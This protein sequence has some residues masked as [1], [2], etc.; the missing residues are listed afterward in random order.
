MSIRY[1]PALRVG[2]VLFLATP[3]LIFSVV[4]PRPLVAAGLLGV[5]LVTLYGYISKGAGFDR[6][7]TSADDAGVRSTITLPVAGFIVLVVIGWV[8]LSGA[9]G[10]GYQNLPDWNNK[11]VLMND[12]LAKPWPVFYGADTVL[13]YYFALYLPPSLIGKLAGWDAA[14]WAMYAYVLIGLMLT[15]LWLYSY[16]ARL[17]VV[18]ILVFVI[19]GGLDIV[20]A[21]LMQR[22]S[23]D[24]ATTIEWWSDR[25]Q[26]SSNATLLYWVP[27][28]AL[29]AWLATALILDEATRQRRLLYTGL[30]VA[31]TFL[32]S[33]FS[34]I[35]LLPVCL[36]AL[37]LAEQ[38]SIMSAANL[39]LLPL[40]A[41]VT[42]AL[43]APHGSGGDLYA[44]A[45]NWRTHYTPEGLLIIAEF[46]L[47]E[48]GVYLACIAACGRALESEWRITALVVTGASVL[49]V[50]VPEAV[51]H[52]GFN[53]RA[54][55][56]TLLL[57]FLLVVRVLSLTSH[58]A[59]RVA[60]AVA[61]VIGADAAAHE[62]FRAIRRRPDTIPAP[63]PTYG[64]LE[65]G[66][67]HTNEFI[68]P[69]TSTL[70]RTFF[71][72]APIGAPP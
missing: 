28:H 30:F 7:T 71:R 67:R 57:L 24:W 56:P 5:L 15:M 23:R 63:R 37:L 32:W 68:M 19:F 58:T 26:F 9:G 18:A 33:P 27:Q 25:L 22:P 45:S 64:V 42:F 39:V 55:I 13:N 31:L 3:W 43:Y 38:K 11:N 60:L 16:S 4:W 49:W 12:L 52:G 48:V 54:S 10:I 36:V 46:L 65:L 21:W 66:K 62:T 47:L 1:L 29:S 51:G 70:Y 35:G 8:S 17:G 72:S 34:A 6:A 41:V 69:A 61:L 53:M 14:Q 50:L 40:L 20:G 44:D 59:V 2:S